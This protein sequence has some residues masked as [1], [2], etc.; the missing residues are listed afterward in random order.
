M[1]AVFS[2]TIL[3]F[4]FVPCLAQESIDIQKIISMEIQDYSQEI[5]L[6]NL[7]GTSFANNDYEV[8]IWVGFS[9]FTPR[10]FLFHQNSR[11][12][13][14]SY[15]AADS[16]S[17]KIQ[18]NKTSLNKPKSGWNNFRQYLIEQ[19]ISLTKKPYPKKEKFIDPDEEL[20]V[21]EMK[22]KD[23]YLLVAYLIRTINPRGKKV[24]DICRKVEKEFA[25]VRL[26]C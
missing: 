11:E 26:G 25:V 2:L 10:L 21:I 9:L 24:L 6:S 12:S 1:K 7:E 20:V 4:L 13:L 23:D 22:T 8:R 17:R 18:Y 14:A 3:V 5:G 19:Q 15:Y 16:A